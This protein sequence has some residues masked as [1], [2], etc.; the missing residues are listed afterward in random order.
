MLRG[1]RLGWQAARILWIFPTASSSVQTMNFYDFKQSQS[2]QPNGSQV[3]GA[4]YVIHGRGSSD[5]IERIVTRI[6]GKW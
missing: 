3:F 4:V 2:H 5:E 6:F 1:G